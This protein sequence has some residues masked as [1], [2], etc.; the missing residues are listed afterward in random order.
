M[1]YKEMIK[2]EAY[3]VMK[4]KTPLLLCSH[5]FIQYHLN[6]GEP[7]ERAIG[8]ATASWASFQ[9]HNMVLKEFRETSLRMELATF[10]LWHRLLTLCSSLLLLFSSSA[11]RFEPR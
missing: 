10:P 7:T 1:R 11:M 4:S 3:R 9:T 5:C 8:L 2:A 6:H